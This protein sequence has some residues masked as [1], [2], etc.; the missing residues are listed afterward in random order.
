MARA[1]QQEQV[2]LPR[3]D[4]LRQ[5]K[6]HA[7]IQLLAERDRLVKAN[8]CQKEGS[9]VGLGVARGIEVE[10]EWG[11]QCSI[12]KISE[13]DLSAAHGIRLDDGGE[14]HVAESTSDAW[15]ENGK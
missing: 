6:G 14:A 12:T 1:C 2:V 4:V 8:A 7:Q 3:G 13:R 11:D 15:C 10:R 9:A 5:N